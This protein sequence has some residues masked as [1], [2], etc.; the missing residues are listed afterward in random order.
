MRLDD[1]HPRMHNGLKPLHIRCYL[2]ASALEDGELGN[3]QE[4]NR[5]G[6]YLQE[7]GRRRSG[8][9]RLDVDTWEGAGGNHLSCL[10]VS[11]L[12]GEQ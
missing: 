10:H 4:I 7:R 3:R 12:K 2:E 1:L 6:H 9:Y 8:N 5:P 11:I